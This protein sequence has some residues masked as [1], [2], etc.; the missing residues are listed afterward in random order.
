M[1]QECY[2]ERCFKGYAGKILTKCKHG[3]PFNIPQ[4]TEEKDEDGIHYLY[5]RRCKEDQ[6]VVPYNLE[7]IFFRGA[8]MNIQCVARHGLKMYLSKYGTALD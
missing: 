8:S 7:I 6:L 3:F 1:H 5:I 4:L 2:P